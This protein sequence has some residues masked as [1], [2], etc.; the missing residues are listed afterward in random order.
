MTAP[1]TME[2]D[3]DAGSWVEHIYETHGHKDASGVQVV[4]SNVLIPL[5]EELLHHQRSVTQGNERANPRDN[6]HT[7]DELYRYRMLYNAMA[8]NAI[9]ESGSMPICKSWFHSDGEPCFGGG[10]FIVVADLP[11][12]QVSNHYQQQHWDL[13]RVPAVTRPPSY[14]GHTPAQAAERIGE[15]LDRG[16]Q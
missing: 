11:T 16:H 5:V 7:M 4:Y 10:W 13:F 15:Y 9:A 3:P 1:V 8:F 14:D 12:G 2:A 6:F